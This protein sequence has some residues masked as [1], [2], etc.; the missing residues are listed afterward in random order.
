[1][2]NCLGRA[3]VCFLFMAL[4]SISSVSFT[5]NAQEDDFI[6]EAEQR[7]ETYGIGGTCIPGTHNLAVD[8]VDSDGS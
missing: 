1:M 3:L 4:I 7:W 5:V 8:D 6:L 2:A